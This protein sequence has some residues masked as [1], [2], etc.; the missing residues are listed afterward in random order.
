MVKNENCFRLFDPCFDEVISVNLSLFLN[1]SAYSYIVFIEKIKHL[2]TLLSISE[3]TWERYVPSF[4][5]RLY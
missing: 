3:S 4:K 5:E 2:R 1:N